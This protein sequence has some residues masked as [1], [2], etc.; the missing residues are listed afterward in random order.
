MARCQDALPRLYG[1]A[2]VDPGR[3][4]GGSMADAKLRIVAFKKDGVDDWAGE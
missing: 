2:D 1:S 4:I 3:P